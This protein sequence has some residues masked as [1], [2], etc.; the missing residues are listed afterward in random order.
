MTAAQNGLYTPRS[1]RLTY[2]YY[3]SKTDLGIIKF[4]SL[5]TAHIQLNKKSYRNKNKSI[6]FVTSYC[7]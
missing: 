4:F 5:Q 6:S 1:M 2:K 3:R 7:S